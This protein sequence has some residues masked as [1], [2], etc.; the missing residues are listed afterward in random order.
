MAIGS[1]TGATSNISRRHNLLTST[2]NATDGTND[3]SCAHNVAMLTNSSP[4]CN[5][6]T[7]SHDTGRNNAGG[8]IRRRGTGVGSVVWLRKH[9]VTPLM[10]STQFGS[11]FLPSASHIRT[12]SHAVRADPLHHWP[13]RLRHLLQSW[14]QQTSRPSS[15][16]LN[17]RCSGPGIQP[18]GTMSVCHFS[19]KGRK[20]RRSS[21]HTISDTAILPYLM[22]VSHI[23]LLLVLL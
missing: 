20:K 12:D 7:T 16:D 19:R 18:T 17:S 6:C 21:T 9:S 10:L 1:R 8:P 3:T 4:C 14:H 22:L 11:D 23:S 2:P 15:W 5:R 13:A